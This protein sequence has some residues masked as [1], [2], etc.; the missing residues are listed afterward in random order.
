MPAAPE[1]MA[2]S[3][4]AVEQLQTVAV[5]ATAVTAPLVRDSYE[6]LTPDEAISYSAGVSRGGEGIIW[7]F[8]ASTITDGWG[9]RS[10]SVCSSFHHGLDFAPGGGSP[11]PVMADGIITEAV[12]SDGGLGTYVTVEH[13]FDGQHVQSRYAHMVRGSLSVAVGQ[14]VHAGDILGIVGSTGQ[15][16]GAHLHLEIQVAGQDRQDPFGWLL[17]NAG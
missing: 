8:P 11:I 3:T 6:V 12:D 1:V 7:P 16:T 15:S 4:P 14:I 10:C 9:P 17:N 5:A 2:A 13:V